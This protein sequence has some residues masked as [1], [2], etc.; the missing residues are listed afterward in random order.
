M[1]DISHILT[2]LETDIAAAVDEVATSRRQRRL[3]EAEQMMLAAA[4][5]RQAV[6]DFDFHG[7]ALYPL[8]RPY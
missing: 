1:T 6:R 2:E 5:Y 4:E 8:W 7:D 3:D